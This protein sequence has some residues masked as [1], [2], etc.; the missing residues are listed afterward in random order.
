VTDTSPSTPPSQTPAA[1]TTAPTR[2]G[3]RHP[4]HA[5]ASWL[6]TGLVMLCGFS[7]WLVMD[8][9]VLQHSA[10]TSTLGT[11]RSVALAILDKLAWLSDHTG[12]DAP[13][14]AANVV[15]NRTSVG[16][17]A[18]PTVPP[19]STTTTNPHAPTTTTTV[20]RLHPSR[21][22]PLRVLLVGDSIG[23]DMDGPLLADL[24]ATGETIVWTD[25]H[26]S[27]GLTRLDYFNW[28]AELRYD[29]YTYKPQVVI[30]MMG[31]N[32]SQSFLY[33][34]T[35]FGTKAWRLRYARNVDQFFTIGKGDGR[36]MLWVSVPIISDH[37]ESVFW[38]TVRHIQEREAGIHHVFY[39]DS[40][41]TLDPGGTF[42][43]YLRV[44]GGLVLA[45]TPND[46]IHLEPA[47]GDLLAQAVLV[48]ME[49]DLHIRLR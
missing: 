26:V 16:G 5:R 40:D 30:G 3:P 22:H 11:R 43:W 4:G 10:D 47:G 13:V 19:S 29:V 20:L 12:L 14:A 32:D 2:T 33:P 45:R 28:I 6:R 42:H 44:G 24:E 41:K 17:F 23:G 35:Y 18:I 48:D 39:I 34:L 37:G 9:T 27:T 49:Q 38:N 31:A 1:P 21:R 15:L 8:S 46:G 36:K 25:D 7:V